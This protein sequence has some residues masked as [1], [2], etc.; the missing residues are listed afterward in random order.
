MVARTGS[1][2]IAEDL[3]TLLHYGCYEDAENGHAWEPPQEIVEIVR[4]ADE[5]FDQSWDRAWPALVPFK[6]TCPKC[7]TAAKNLML[8][9]GLDREAVKRLFARVGA[10]WS[11][12]CR[13]TDERKKMDDSGTM[14]ADPDGPGFILESTLVARRKRQHQAAVMAER[15][16]DMRHW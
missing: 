6:P 4:N 9:R 8:E 1:R 10:S 7:K 15:K 14:I 3:W 2:G 5:A 12:A 13:A 11:W 16:A